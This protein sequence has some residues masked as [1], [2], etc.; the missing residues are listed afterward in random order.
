MA[1]S[2]KTGKKFDPHSLPRHGKQKAEEDK[3][4][5]RDGLILVKDEKKK[6][7]RLHR[8]GKRVLSS[9]G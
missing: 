9:Q 5:M 2:K 7:G 4:A 3:R 1:P 8:R 6:K